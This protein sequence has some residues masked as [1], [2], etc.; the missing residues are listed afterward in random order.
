LSPGR[1][2]CAAVL[3]ALAACSPGPPAGDPERGRLLYLSGRRP[4]GTPLEARAQGD[5]P[6][7]GADAACVRCHQRSGMGS[8]EGGMLVL[9]ITGPRLA[10]PQEWS[11]QDLMRYLYREEQERA[12]KA[13]L[14]QM[15]IRP[16][17]DRPSLIRAL[18]EGLRPDGHPLDPAMPRY[19]LSEEDARDLA[20]WLERL[21][22]APSPG[23]DE[24]RI[25]F[26]TVILPDADPGE[27]TALLETL[28]AWKERRN[29]HVL[30]ELQKPGHSVRFKDTLYDALRLWELHVWRLEGPPSSWPEQLTALLEEQPVFALVSG[31]GGPRFG[32]G[33]VQA[34]CE[35]EGLPCLFPWTALPGEED[36]AWYSFWFH[37]GVRLEARALAVFLRQRKDLEGAAQLVGETAEERA[38]AA[39]LDAALGRPLPRAARVEELPAPPRVLVA[40]GA[41][42]PRPGPAGPERVYATTR[43]LTARSAAELA[44]LPAGLFF[45]TP[46]APDPLL[47]P[48]IRQDRVWFRNQELPLDHERLR[49]AAY[50]AARSLDNAL[51]HLFEDFYR[52]FL[53]ES[54][55]HG[56]E[57]R[58]T[59]GPFHRLSLG[60][61]QRH[62]ARGCF[63][64]RPDPDA[65]GGL[66]VEEAWTVPGLAE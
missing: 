60:R 31:L 26:A 61:D 17:Y 57:E 6:V 53:V 25:H 39:A 52:D 47:E 55:E 27:A 18:R 51:E 59:F 42:L 11:N 40:W 9:P 44:S 49:L 4:D 54:I 35:A 15:R 24:E 19:R 32:W 30:W 62:A 21:G 1:R 22:A 33:P 8:A 29:Q 2:G 64:L 7:R 28:E 56:T 66:A 50:F 46:C 58:M 36:G 45:V 37:E 10:A 38:G 41:A 16:A 14:L 20:A 3:L 63:L 65:E 23:V 5:V 34:W 48:A 13:K 43:A 12:F